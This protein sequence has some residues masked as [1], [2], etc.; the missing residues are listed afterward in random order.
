MPMTIAPQ[1]QRGREWKEYM[2]PILDL[3][4]VPT[5]GMM[6]RQKEE[7]QR[8]MLVARLGTQ[9]PLVLTVSESQSVGGGR[10]AACTSVSEA[11]A[12]SET[13]SDSTPCSSLT[14][15][16]RRQRNG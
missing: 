12:T 4:S 7:E 5:L 1:I 14:D 10:G 11:K 6:L 16:F 8:D 15:S 9:L 3:W 13:F 2:L